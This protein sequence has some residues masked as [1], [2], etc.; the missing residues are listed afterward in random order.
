MGTESRRKDKIFFSAAESTVGTPETVCLFEG[1]GT[2]T[3]PEPEWQIELNKGKLGAGQFGTKAE[4]QAAWVPWSYTG[5]RIDELSYFLSFGLGT[6]DAPAT[7]EAGVYSHLNMPQI[8]TSRTLPVFTMEYGLGSASANAVYSH[9]IVNEVTFSTESGGTGVATFTASG[10]ANAH[11]VTDGVFAKLTA[12]SMASGTENVLA[13]PL[14]NHRC[15]NVWQGV[16][17]D[18]VTNATVDYTTN[19]LAASVV[20]LTTLFS[21]ISFSF[22]NGLSGDQLARAGGC[23]L[24]NY[25]E[26]ND[27]TI[28][29]EFTLTKDDATL[30]PNAKI[31]ANTQNAIELLFE[32]PIVATTQNYALK[33]IFPLTQ[34][35]GAPE[36]DDA[37]IQRTVAVDVQETDTDG[38]LKVFTQTA[39]SV[40]YNAE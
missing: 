13:G 18:S 6:L 33:L 10:F 17:V 32:G 27:P 20:D 4:L 19:N 11:S 12:G 31:V 1:N 22:S 3:F 14:I 34:I 5:E 16:G 26:R 40:G 8:V 21:G 23:G 38:A 2:M 25:Q 37:P 35:L 30:D 36:G 7:I 24:L 9:C 29:L 39:Y 28:S 15:F